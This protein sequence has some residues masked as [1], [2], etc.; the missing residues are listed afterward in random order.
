MGDHAHDNLKTENGFLHLTDGFKNFFFRFE[1][2]L[3]TAAMVQKYQS[4]VRVYKHPFELIM[5]VSI[6]FYCHFLPWQFL[7]LQSKVGKGSV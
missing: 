2:S 5:A 4:P 3:L 7:V 6:N 1:L